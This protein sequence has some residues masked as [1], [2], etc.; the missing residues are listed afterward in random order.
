MQP[1]PRISALTTSA[2]TSFND[3]E[4][5]N[6]PLSTL[7]GKRV[8]A[9]SEFG[10]AA[11][12]QPAAIGAQTHTR[13]AS[14]PG[15]S[16]AASSLGIGTGSST[17]AKRNVPA[18]TASSSS[19]ATPT[20]GAA[21]SS[22]VSRSLSAFSP[23][24]SDIAQ[25]PKQYHRSTSSQG[26]PAVV[27]KSQTA[28]TLNQL[29]QSEMEVV[30]IAGQTSH[31]PAVPSLSSD[32]SG[33]SS[34]VRTPSDLSTAPRPGGAPS[35][36]KK[37]HRTATSDLGTFVRLGSKPNGPTGS[38]AGSSRSG[39][40]IRHAKTRS[41]PLVQFA[42]ADEV[43][44]R[45]QQRQTQGHSGRSASTIGFGGSAPAHQGSFDVALSPLSSQELPPPPGVDP[46]LY[47][48][49][50]WSVCT[51]IHA[52]TDPSRYACS[53]PAD[54][55]QALQQRSQQ[56]MAMMQSFAIQA[57]ND[58]WGRVNA[59]QFATQP[60]QMP[61]FAPLPH[62]F[63]HGQMPM[64]STGMGMPF[65]SFPSVPSFYGYPAVPA[66]LPVQHPQ[67]HPFVPQLPHSPSTSFSSIGMPSTYST[68]SASNQ[69]RQHT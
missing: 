59:A 47:A 60:P 27:R 42:E 10:V 39:H 48:S 31:T 1:L 15:H 52:S 58:A 18:A 61:F 21:A 7:R 44:E 6:V 16:S 57:Q 32:S 17:A 41:V 5:E 67:Q 8:G 64:P 14:G 65:N 34:I 11:Y 24:A 28:V 9:M 29:I 55:K 53:V 26:I 23:S 45:L 66:T 2:L 22:A 40:S 49:C 37:Q 33:G 30:A 63:A 4:E 51:A 43:H 20:A 19:P 12:R 62:T 3:D 46:A 50:E 68:Q 36:F 54:Q 35:D 13:G 25:K 69:Q 56:L 38:T